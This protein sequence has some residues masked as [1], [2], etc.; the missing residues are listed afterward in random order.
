MILKITKLLRKMTPEQLQRA[1]KLILH[2]Y[3]YS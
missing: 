3:I 2:I 1:Y